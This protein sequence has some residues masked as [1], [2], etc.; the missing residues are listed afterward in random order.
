MSEQPLDIDRT[1]SGFA[2]FVVLAFLLLIASITTPFLAAAKIE[3]LVSRNSAF[4]VRDAIALRGVLEMAALRYFELYRDRTDAPFSEVTCELNDVRLNFQFQDHSGLIDLNAASPEV[5]KLGFESLGLTIAASLKLANSVVR[6][7]SVDS[8]APA[9]ELITPRGGN[10][11]AP[12]ENVA[13]L[14]DL[15]PPGEFSNEIIGTVFTVYS[16]TGTID[17]MAAPSA[18][19]ER[20]AL[21]PPTDRYFLVNDTRRTNA[22]TVIASRQQK[23]GLTKYARG[24][25]GEG[26][27]PSGIQILNP[28]VTG[29]SSQI[30]EFAKAGS[31]ASCIDFFDSAMMKALPTVMS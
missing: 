13:E 21:L 7:R 16:G 19:K 29:T 20:I 17:E 11:F 27:V 28:V 5:L 22:V 14:Q 31:A 8:F 30:P 10:K 12:I 24:N 9:P 26:T 25:F 4:A 1:D 23:D 15:L 18:L 6:Y 2:L 3:A